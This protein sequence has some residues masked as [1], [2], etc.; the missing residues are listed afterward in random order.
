MKNQVLDHSDMNT[1]TVTM[2]IKR[3]KYWNLKL[4]EIDIAQTC[5]IMKWVNWFLDDCAE[6]LR[7]KIDAE[8][9]DYIPHALL[10]KVLRAGKIF[11][12]FQPR[13]DGCPS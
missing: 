13:C 9:L 4:D 2:V 7:Q 6:K 12:C 1:S 5:D 11:R 8:I 3:A 10:T